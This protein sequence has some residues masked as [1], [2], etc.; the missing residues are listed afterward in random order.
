LGDGDR[1][2]Y[3]IDVF[4]HVWGAFTSIDHVFFWDFTNK[5]GDLMGFEWYL[6]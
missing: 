4:D 6:E 3:K 2:G 5:N 1:H